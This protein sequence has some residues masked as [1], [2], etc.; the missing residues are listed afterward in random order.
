M[1]RQP[2]ISSIYLGCVGQSPPDLVCQASGSGRG[3]CNPS[4]AETGCGGLS[5]GPSHPDPWGPAYCR[6]RDRGR[7]KVVENCTINTLKV[8][9]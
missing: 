9:Y 3:Q 4:P 2:K 8:T 7:R 1:R 6:E 5:P